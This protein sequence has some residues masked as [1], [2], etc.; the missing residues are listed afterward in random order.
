MF[1]KMLKELV[2][3]YGVSGCVLLARRFY[4]PGQLAIFKTRVGYEII[5]EFPGRSGVLRAK[6]IREVSAIETDKGLDILATFEN[7]ELLIAADL[8]PGRTTMIAGIRYMT[9]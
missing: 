4:E 3:K 5:C 2:T 9:V 1:N 7:E 8:K 6:E